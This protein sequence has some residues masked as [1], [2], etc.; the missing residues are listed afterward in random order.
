MA[1][2]LLLNITTYCNALCEFCVVLDSLNQPDK[3]MTDEQIFAEI[4]Q[5][6]ADGATEVGYTGG[7]PSIHP[8]I[9]EVIQYATDKGATFQSMNTNGL[10][11]KSYDFCKAI[12]EAGL[13]SID[14]SIH[15]HTDELHNRLVQRKGAMQAI[16]QACDNLRRLKEEG[17]EF[18]ISGTTVITQ[19][20]HEHLLATMQLL[21]E[22]GIENKRLK[23]CYEGNLSYDALV[24]QVPPYQ[25]VASSVK[26]S[27]EYL[28]EKK[29]GFHVTHVPLC[30]LGE[31]A[32][33]SRDFERQNA[34]MVFKEKSLEGD[35]AHYFR[36]DGDECDRC[37]VANLC[38]RLDKQY[39]RFHGTPELTPFVSHAEV[40]A[41]F[42]EGQQK[43][44][45]F[46]GMIR[47]N[48]EM[49][50]QNKGAEQGGT[51]VVEAA[52]GE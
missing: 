33:F 23:H 5:A 40:E 4:D 46:A 15:G 44:P 18:H 27:L 11:F 52:A 32:V 47:R 2:H 10:K 30:V 1:R 9:I 7:E 13:T 35:A 22:L 26:D 39:Q 36:K 25:M 37:V 8:R 45:K 20:N 14:F 43:W 50:R 12:I 31:H 19:E 49:Y 24:N 42:E 21:E 17:Y 48:L 51:R 16:R 3:N 41:V 28:A 6:F 38:T 34:R 29:Y